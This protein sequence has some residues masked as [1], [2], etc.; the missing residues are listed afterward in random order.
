[1]STSNDRTLPEDAVMGEG[2]SMDSTGEGRLDGNA[3]GGI[4]AGLFGCEMTAAPGR[5][6]HCGTVNEM[7]AM[8]VYMRGP[9]VV[10]RCPACG[11][12]V[13]RVVETTNATFVDARGAAYV[14]FEREVR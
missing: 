9:G 4:L 14:R 10:I 2:E 1:M 5:C 7:G 6:A 3:A 11:E 13:L 8:H 12:V